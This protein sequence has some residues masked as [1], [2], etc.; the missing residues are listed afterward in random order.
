MN[1]ELIPLFSNLQRAAVRGPGRHELA[2]VFFALPEKPYH[3]TDNFG[4]VWIRPKDLD[5][6]I[7]SV[8]PPVSDSEA[9]LI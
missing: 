6:V 2:R 7:A 1:I 9:S 3:F 4:R 5:A 8:L